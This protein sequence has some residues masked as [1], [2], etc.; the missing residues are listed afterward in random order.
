MKRTALL[1]LTAIYLLST[2]GI[3]ANSHYCR[4]KLQ[5]ITAP[6]NCKASV[7]CKKS[8]QMKNC[9][10]TKKQ[11]FKVS[12]LHI[13]ASAFSLDTRLFPAVQACCLASQTNI[14]AAIQ[15]RFNIDI[16][17]P[18]KGNEISPYILNCNYRI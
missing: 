17:A 3:A 2:L 7:G 13:Y 6:V 1:F 15:V 4:G 9:C 12:D 16:N 8:D 10:K 5:S 18:P 11:Y 14:N